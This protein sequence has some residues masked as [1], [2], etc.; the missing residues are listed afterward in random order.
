MITA[1]EARNLVTAFRESKAELDLKDVYKAIHEYANQGKIGMAIQ[2]E[3]CSE[4]LIACL[5]EAGYIV[6]PRGNHIVV[7]W[8]EESNDYVA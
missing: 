2:S 5:K 8:K 1:E 7:I 3:F 4:K 6:Y